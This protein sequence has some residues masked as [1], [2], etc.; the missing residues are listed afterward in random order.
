MRLSASMTM[1]N[2]TAAEVITASGFSHPSKTARGGAPEPTTDDG[3]PTTDDG[4]SMHALTDVTGFG[5]I[6]HLREMLLASEGVSLS[7]TRNEFPCSKALSIASRPAISLEVSTP[8]SNS[9]NVLL[10]M[11]RDSGGAEADSIRSADGGWAADCRRAGSSFGL[12]SHISRIRSSGNR[13]RRAYASVKA[14]DSSDQLTPIPLLPKPE[15]N[16]APL[17]RM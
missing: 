14:A 1:L 7:F 13:Y 12:G 15:R 16:G 17:V 6:G 4:F 5:L 9:L 2:K 10:V 3:R 8:T 11:T